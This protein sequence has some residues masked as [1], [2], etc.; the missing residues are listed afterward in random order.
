[1]ITTRPR[2]GFPSRV[3]AWT[4]TRSST[5]IATRAMSGVLAGMD[6]QEKISAIDREP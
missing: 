3:K 4:T 2:F 6:A 5:S 1:M